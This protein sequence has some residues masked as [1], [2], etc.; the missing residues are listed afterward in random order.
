MILFSRQRGARGLARKAGLAVLGLAIVVGGFAVMMAVVGL[1]RSK[2]ET[3]D[4][5]IRVQEDS[6]LT[7]YLKVKY[8]GVDRQGVES[9]DNTTA[10]VRS[11]V[12]VV[13]DR[14]PNGLIFQNFVESPSGSF[15]AV[16]RKDGTTACAGRVIDDTGDVTGWNAGN[17]EFVYHGLHYDKATNTVNFQVRNLKAGCELSVGIVTRTPTLPEGVRRMD[18]YNMAGITEGPIASSSN[19]VHTWIGRDVSVYNVTY[20]YTGDVPA[21]APS[22]P[23]SMS[24]PED[25]EVSVATDARLDGYVFSGWI[26]TD[27]E[28]DDNQFVMPSH[29]VHLVGSFTAKPKY[30]VSYEIDGDLEPVSYHKPNTKE[31]GENDTV[32]VDTLAAGTALDGYR[33]SGWTTNDVTVS[34]EGVFTMPA[35][36]VVFHGSF[37]QIKHKVTYAFEGEV[38]P[39]GWESLIPAQ[40]EYAIGE[41]VTTAAAPTADGYKFSGWYKAATFAMPDEDVTIYGEW[42]VNIGYFR[43]V[44]TQVIDDYKDPYYNTETVKF[45]ITVTNTAEYPIRLVNVQLKDLEGAHFT[46]TRSFTIRNDDLA[47]IDQLD[48][49]ETATLWAEFTIPSNEDVDYQNTAEIISAVAE[50]NHRFD[51][52]NTDTYSSTVTFR[53]VKFEQD[54]PL[55]GINQGY[56]IPFVALIALGAMGGT[57]VVLRRR[58]NK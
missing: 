11:D 24:Y 49:G 12:I 14:I 58:A 50:N 1:V 3:I 23:S 57:V 39:D 56:L 5:G 16:E 4:D 53:S 34:A 46:T 27:V 43:P 31:Y 10:E 44:L 47:Q 42:S 22:L 13:S 29:D 41:T 9:N 28:I 20:S 15:G 32:E 52:E 48:A 7:Y 18:F 2:A 26:S 8:D 19:T 35:N 37:E 51:T 36:A 38:L 33:F 40:A 6:D 45:T 30:Q 55:A 21:N 25:M 54:P 17:T